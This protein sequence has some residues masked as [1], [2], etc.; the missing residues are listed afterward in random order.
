MTAAQGAPGRASPPTGRPAPPPGRG[1]PDRGGG[2]RRS[3]GSWRPSTPRRGK[4]ARAPTA[5]RSRPGGGVEAAVGP[6]EPEAAASLAGPG[7]PGGH[8]SPFARD[9]TLRRRGSAQ[10]RRGAEEGAAAPREAT[11]TVTA[12]PRSRGG[13]QGATTAARRGKARRRRAGRRGGRAGGDPAHPCFCAGR[14]DG[15]SRAYGVPGGSKECARGAGLFSRF[16]CG[17]PSGSWGAGSAE[18]RHRRC[19]RASAAPAPAPPPP[20]QS[21]VGGH[22]LH[23]ERAFAAT[24]LLIPS[25]LRYRSR[26]G[27]EAQLVAVARHPPAL[28]GG[29]G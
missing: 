5:G 23:C 6:G 14:R 10:P 15:S 4:P 28:S 20:P 1:S 2:Q 11:P 21:R 19:E 26:P 27:R 29:E 8:R 17:A 25:W 3:A 7:L 24:R 13:R 12:P 16:A 18:R 9:P 22:L